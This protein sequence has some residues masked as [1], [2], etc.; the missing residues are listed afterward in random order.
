MLFAG[1]YTKGAMLYDFQIILGKTRNRYTLL[2]HD[3]SS[4]LNELSSTVYLTSSIIRKPENILS[5]IILRRTG[6]PL[7][8]FGDSRVMASFTSDLNIASNYGQLLRENCEEDINYTGKD[9]KIVAYHKNP[10]VNTFITR[11]DTLDYKELTTSSNSLT[12]V[13]VSGIRTLKEL[14]ELYDLSWILNDDGSLKKD[15][16]TICTKEELD[17]VIENVDNAEELAFDVET[18]GLKFYYMGGHR[19]DADEIVGV[20]LSWQENQGVYIPL[21]SEKFECLSREYVIDKLFPHLTRFNLDGANILFDLKVAYHYGYLFKC[22]FDTMQAEFDLDPTGSRGHKSLKAMTRYYIGDETLELDEVL[23][24][25]VDGKLIKFLDKDVI[26]IYGC[27]DADYVLKLKHILKPLL[28][29]METAT[30]LDFNMIPVCAIAEYYSNHVD[31]DLLNV[32]SDVNQRDFALVDKTLREYLKLMATV[33]VSA[34]IAKSRYPT[35][36]LSD[37]IRYLSTT[38]EVANLVDQLLTVEDKDGRRPL[39]FKSSDDLDI[40]F[41]KILNYPPPKIKKRLGKKESASKDDSYLVSLAAHKEKDSNSFM[42]ED[43]MSTLAEYNYDWIDKKDKILLSKD[44]INNCKYP[45][46]IMLQQW[47]KLDKRQSG[48][49]NRLLDLS[50]HGYY[51]TENKMT[52]ADTARIINVAQ[53]IQGYIKSLIIPFPNKYM[54]V[55]DAAQIEFR[56]MIGLASQ[57]WDAFCSQLGSEGEDFKNKSINTVAEKLN[58]P[59]ADYHREGGSLLVGKTPATMNKEDRSKVKGP[60]FA[61]PYG[62]SAS[63][64][65]ANELNRLTSEKVKKKKIEETD[66]LLGVWR[67]KMYP[68]YRFLETKRDEAVTLITNDDELPPRLKGGKWGRV[69]NAVGRRRYYNLDFE[70]TAKSLI[71][72]EPDVFSKIVANKVE[73][74]T[75]LT[76]VEER[77]WRNYVKDTEKVITALIRRS[78]GNYPIQSLAREYFVLMMTRL[79]NRLHNKGYMGMGPDNDKIILNMLVHDEG[80]LQVDYS[81]HPYE[82]YKDITECCMLN[83]KGYPRIYC[84]ISIC[85]NWHDGKED[86]YEAPV[87]FVFDKAKEYAANPEKFNND[88]WRDDPQA[89]VH[90]DI[91]KWMHEYTVKFINEN[92]VDNVFNLTQFR[93]TNENYFLFVKL[94]MYTNKFTNKEPDISGEELIIL[95]HNENPNLIVKTDT[96]E[97]KWSEYKFDYVDVVKTDTNDKVESKSDL[98]SEFSDNIDDLLDLNFEDLE[99]EDL[100]SDENDEEYKEQDAANCYWLNSDDNITEIVPTTSSYNIEYFEDEEP[101]APDI[102]DYKRLLNI[103]GTWCLDLTGLS[104]KRLRLVSNYLKS[105]KAEDGEP[106]MYV[107]G[108]IKRMLKYKVKGIKAEDLK[109]LTENEI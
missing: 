76:N 4:L 23:G 63:T 32:F 87:E 80:H 6:Q 91:V 27:A 50:C 100:F 21:E 41:F 22:G 70:Q 25:P 1:V 19:K 16:K 57:Y 71:K 52:N 15:Y 3:N 39:N 89:Y 51:L 98:T 54:I 37:A 82:L 47:R 58:I 86:I 40:V 85:H 17:W 92:T 83:I 60:H 69:T 45:F 44:A 9:F 12:N 94:G 30:Q 26:T 34:D 13:K 33:N 66:L 53:T 8:E 73:T 95:S 99:F 49:Y 62:G 103:A 105:H 78:S 11:K 75:P 18:T 77:Y 64:V 7:L 14:K 106:L 96:R 48:F 81:I 101:D 107:D 61:V 109:Y 67:N 56:V 93:Q 24:G 59:W 35:S 42:K 43:L 20:C 28:K 68:L 74:N 90:K 72:G 102:L 79:F 29:H 104:E 31:M 46:A 55:F 97:I 84:G 108:V 5:Q 38:D 10:N 36:D 88:N 2:V 65:A